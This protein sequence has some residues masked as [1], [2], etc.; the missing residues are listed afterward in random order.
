MAVDCCCCRVLVPQ[1]SPVMIYDICRVDGVV[2]ISAHPRARGARCVRCGRVS[3][4]VHSRYRRQP[5]GSAGRRSADGAV[6]DGAPVLL[7]SGQLHNRDVRR[8]GSGSDRAVRAAQRRIAGCSG[9]HRGCFG[10]EGRVEVGYRVG[11]AGQPL[12]V[13]APDPPPAG[14]AGR[15]GD[16]AWCRRI[17]VASRT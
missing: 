17:R 5:G 9:I 2:M 14:S 4:R 1:L 16:G 12:Y 13:A 6:A 10:R 11:Y 3:T 8:A 7:R 15:S